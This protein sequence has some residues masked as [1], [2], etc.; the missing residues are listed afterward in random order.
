MRDRNHSTQSA[1][2]PPMR[3]ILPKQTLLLKC[4]ACVDE[5]EAAQ[6][7][8]L[9]RATIR[10]LVPKSDEPFADDQVRD[11]RSMSDAPPLPAYK[12]FPDAAK[13]K[14]RDYIPCGHRDCCMDLYRFF[15][16]TK[17]FFGMEEEAPPLNIAAVGKILVSHIQ[18]IFLIGALSL[19]WS[20]P[21]RY[22]T[23]IFHLASGPGY[24]Y[25]SAS[26]VEKFDLIERA[27]ALLVV[28][29][30]FTFPL[31]LVVSLAI[32]W[33]CSYFVLNIKYCGRCFAWSFMRSIPIP[34]TCN[35]RCTVRLSFCPVPFDR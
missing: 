34:N 19:K 13:G 7:N 15:R 11:E 4:I 28:L 21:F 8:V 9:R 22:L 27:A 25:A 23:S 14:C 6:S 35:R 2:P 5:S 30:L 1:M 18:F 33:R 20:A 32:F 10:N 17:K 24:A 29:L 26:C 12:G 31:L 3:S 16:A